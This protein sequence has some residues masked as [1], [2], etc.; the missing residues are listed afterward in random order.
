M[1]AERGRTIAVMAHETGKTVREGDPEVSEADRLRPLGGGVHARARRPRRRRRGRR[2]A[3]RRARRRAVELPDRHPGQRRRSPRSPAG[4]A[5]ILKPAPEAV[6]TAV[7]LVRHVHAAGV[8]ADV[9]QLVRCPDDDTGRHLV[10]HDGVDAVVLTG[11]YDTARLFLGWKPDLHL[12][13]ETSG[14]NAL[15]I[16]QTADVDLAARATSCARRSATPARSARPPASPSSR[17]RCTTTR[18][19]LPRAS[20]TPCARSRV[21]PADRPAPR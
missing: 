20:P 5:V 18:A 6:A 8:P 2:P 19:F 3:R 13:A 11:A 9:V 1:A 14:K 7:E 16:S 17:R 15:V 10:T 21:G 4:N 12:L